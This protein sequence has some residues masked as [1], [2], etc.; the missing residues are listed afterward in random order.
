[1]DNSIF[2]EI[3]KEK[4][5]YLTDEYN[6]IVSDKNDEAIKPYLVYKKDNIK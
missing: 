3:C 4:F 5:L 6:F 1:M 2:L